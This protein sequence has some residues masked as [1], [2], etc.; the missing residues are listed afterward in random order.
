MQGMN[1]MGPTTK[2]LIAMISNLDNYLSSTYMSYYFSLFLFS[3]G[4]IFHA[5][6]L[7]LNNTKNLWF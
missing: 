1:L 4:N 5:A 2:V 3:T 7:L 6:K